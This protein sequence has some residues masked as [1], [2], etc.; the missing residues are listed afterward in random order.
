MKGVLRLGV[1]RLRALPR[2]EASRHLSLSLKPHSLL[3]LS[4][5]LKA[6]GCIKA[7]FGRL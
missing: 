3:S 5:S 4:L 6:V 1:L 7:P 2:S